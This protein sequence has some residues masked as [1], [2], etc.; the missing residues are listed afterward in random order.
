MSKLRLYV[1]CNI[2]QMENKTNAHQSS[3]RAGLKTL[4]QILLLIC[5]HILTY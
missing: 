5:Q 2:K 3:Q 1:L 4:S